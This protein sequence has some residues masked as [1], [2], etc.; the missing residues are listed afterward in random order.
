[1]ELLLH[2]HF[3]L[4]QLVCA[5]L[6]HMKCTPSAESH[7]RSDHRL[8][9]WDPGAAAASIL[10]LVLQTSH[11]TRSNSTPGPSTCRGGAI[12]QVELWPSPRRQP[13]LIP[14]HGAGGPVETR[15]ASDLR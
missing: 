15:S 7:P 9:P 4:F 13:I 12:S 5:P 6:L 11:L 2:S 8:Y 10:V 1:M 3:F 14:R